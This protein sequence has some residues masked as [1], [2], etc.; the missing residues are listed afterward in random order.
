MMFVFLSG[1]ALAVILTCPD[2][3]LYNS[4]PEKW[5]EPLKE[6]EQTST[7]KKPIKKTSKFL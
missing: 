6:E 2:W 1:V 7:T 4:N 5:L 3:P